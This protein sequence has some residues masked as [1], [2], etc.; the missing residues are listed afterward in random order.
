[1]PAFIREVLIHEMPDGTL[2]M[3]NPLTGRSAWW[4][5]GRSGRPMMH[6]TPECIEYEHTRE[7]ED[8]CSFCPVNV[9]EA[10]PEIERRI[11]DGDGYRSEFH[12]LPGDLQESEWA[13]RRVTNLYEIV[14]LDYWRRNYDYRGRSG[15]H[16]W[17]EAYKS[18]AR[19]REHLLNLVRTK[20]AAMREAGEEIP[21]RSEDEMLEEVDSFFLGCHQLIIGSRH[22]QPDAQCG[23]AQ[24]LQSSGAFSSEE[25]FEYLRFTVDSIRDI[26]EQNRYVRYVVA[27]QNWMRPSGASFDHLHKQL[28]G[29]DDWGTLITR[30]VEACRSDPNYYNSM[31]VN[32]AGYNNLV[33]AENEHAVLYADFGH[34]NPTLAIYSKSHHLRPFEHEPEELRGISDLVHACH[35]AQGSDTS[36][37]EEWYYQPRDCL[38]RIPFHIL[39]KWRVNNPAGFEG[40]TSIFINPVRPTDV[41]DEIVPNLFKLREEGRIAAGIRIAEECP[42]VPNSLRYNR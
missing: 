15:H 20:T 39:I 22:F 1:M 19:G 33:I 34:R 12:L 8:Y 24:T 18:D 6:Q 16:E 21:D 37:N 26:H 14:T 28:V 13:F 30:E 10:P 17:A 35:A 27:F 29:L 42:V 41:R 5:P 25:H 38:E 7:P 23:N 3:T 9:L 11:P 2:K 40:G 4:V 32:F 36:C 31:V